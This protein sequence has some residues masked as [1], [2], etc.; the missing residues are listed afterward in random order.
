MQ[1]KQQRINPV[2]K[3]AQ[4]LQRC[5][6]FVDRKKRQRQGYSKHKKAGVF[7]LPPSY[8]S[9]SVHCT[10]RLSYLT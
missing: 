3:A 6:A 2:A 8:L 7:T 4:Q 1:K 9:T 10:W 5:T